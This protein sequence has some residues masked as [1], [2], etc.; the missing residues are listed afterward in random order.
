MTINYQHIHT[1]GGK[2]QK[3]NKQANK[4]DTYKL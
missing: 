4:Q 2:K 3:T 1:S